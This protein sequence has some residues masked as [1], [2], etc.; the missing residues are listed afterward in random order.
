MLGEKLQLQFVHPL[1]KLENGEE[2]HKQRRHQGFFV[3]PLPL[4]HNQ[5]VQAGLRVFQLPCIF[6]TLFSCPCASLLPSQLRLHNCLCACAL[7]QIKE[8]IQVD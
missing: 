6:F 1:H 8:I 5:D 2:Q 3:V 4:P 7:H